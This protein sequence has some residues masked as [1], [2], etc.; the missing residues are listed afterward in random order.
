MTG[1]EVIIFLFG[2]AWYVISAIAQAKDK[3]KKKEARQAAMM[4]EV[5][6]SPEEA[7]DGDKAGK[8]PA[9]RQSDGVVEILA[10]AKSQLDEAVKPEKFSSPSSPKPVNV[11]AGS[12]PQPTIVRDARK[13][14]LDAMRKEMGLGTAEAAKPAVPVE[15]ASL[16]VPAQPAPAPLSVSPSP[17]VSRATAPRRSTQQP[18]ETAPTPRP[19]RSSQVQAMSPVGPVSGQSVKD[20]LHSPGS[21]RQA[22][23]LTEV[24]GPPVSLRDNHLGG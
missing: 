16:K 9:E 17:P 1:W 21:L 24:L 4:K 19:R 12:K 5:R 13:A 6:P 11:Q 22:M 3:K 23:V 10:T 20:Y 2:G 18:S 8:I 7:A 15:T 14:I